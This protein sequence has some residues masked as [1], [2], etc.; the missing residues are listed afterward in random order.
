MLADRWHIPNS[1]IL[2]YLVETDDLLLWQAYFELKAERDDAED[3][4]MQSPE[5][6]AEQLRG[7]IHG[8]R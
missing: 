1:R 4:E 7:K 3:E 6:F 5:Q 8:Q 2:G